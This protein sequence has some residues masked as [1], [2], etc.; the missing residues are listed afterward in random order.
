M[1]VGQ[2]IKKFRKE[3]KITLK[4]LGNHLGISEQAVSQYEREIRTPNT[5]LV[6]R[7]AEFLNVPA[8]KIDYELY[9]F[10]ELDKS[11]YTEM[12]KLDE[13]KSFINLIK[14]SGFETDFPILMGGSKEELFEDIDRQKNGETPFV[15]IS[16]NKNKI[17]LNNDEFNKL[18]E[19]VCRFLKFELMEKFY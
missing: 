16:Y 19:K 5:K 8:Y 15:Y 1:G 11:N 6:Y 12:E 9:D 7:I 2:N 18:L 3:K 14:Y 10:M 17:E 4:Q 13:I